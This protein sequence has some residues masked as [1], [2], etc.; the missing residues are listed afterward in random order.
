M[1]KKL[2]ECDFQT[3]E[4][5]SDVR[6]FW[7]KKR[8]DRQKKR[9]VYA[10]KLEFKNLLKSKKFVYALLFGS[11]AKWPK[12][13]N[14]LPAIAIIGNDGAGKT[15]ICDYI[16]KNFSKIDPAFINMK[17]NEPLFSFTKYMNKYLRKIINYSIIQKIT[18][19]I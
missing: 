2:I 8:I 5:D 3:F 12:N 15:T 4:L 10:G 17:S 9:K 14:P 18:I 11:L 19:L 6:N 1:D 13:H 7:K 16:I